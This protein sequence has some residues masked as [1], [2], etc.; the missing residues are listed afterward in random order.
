MILLPAGDYICCFPEMDRQWTADALL[1][2]RLNACQSS[3]FSCD[4][5][6][7]TRIESH[8]LR[9]LRRLAG[10]H[11]TSKLLVYQPGGL[12]RTVIW[13]TSS[14]PWLLVLGT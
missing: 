3:G 11:R 1:K 8:T 6:E 12:K 5:F 2:W 14:I 13:A 4:P 10:V 9:T 7:P